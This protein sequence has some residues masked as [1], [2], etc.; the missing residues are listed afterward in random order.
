MQGALTFRYELHDGAER[1]DPRA[2]RAALE[3]ALTRS[4][5]GL[6]VC[7]GELDVLFC[8]ARASHLLGRLGMG[9]DRVLPDAVSR[10]AIAQ[11]AAGDA[12][13]V[14]RIPPACIG[15]AVY[16]QATPL[17]GA[18]PAR[19]AIWLREEILRDDL[20][21]AAMK[22]E[23]AISPR[24]FQLAQLVRKGLSNRLIAAQMQLAESTVKGYLH[25]LYRDC[26][27][28]S[29][30]GLIALLSRLSG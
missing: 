9:A 29:R 11:L 5:E 13:R 8:T 3:C 18:P 12:S 1:L 24:D 26:G 22:A 7:D 10:A 23:F 25:R 4:G 28:R 2:W 19:A 6:V 27:V 14:D 16:V 30:T 21:F 17:R 20:L 15:G